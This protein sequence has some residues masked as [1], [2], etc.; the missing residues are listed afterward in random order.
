MTLIFH[1]P[2]RKIVIHTS[3]GERTITWHGGLYAK[4]AELVEQ[5][6]D[7]LHW[8]AGYHSSFQMADACPDDGKGPVTTDAGWRAV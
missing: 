3:D 2:I 8:P 6:E 7:V 1:N 4:P 5:I